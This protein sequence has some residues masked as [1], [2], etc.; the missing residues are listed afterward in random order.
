MYADPMQ[1]H[2]STKCFADFIPNILLIHQDAKNMHDSARRPQDTDIIPPKTSISKDQPANSWK[3]H[4][5]TAATVG[6]S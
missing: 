4:Q 1:G 2:I 3:Q 6:T 5:L